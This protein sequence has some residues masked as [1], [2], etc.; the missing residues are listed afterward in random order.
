MLASAMTPL[1]ALTVASLHGARFIGL[2]RDL[3]SLETGK[4]ADFM[5]LNTNPLENIRNTK[6][7]LYVMKGGVLYDDETLDEV[8]P[9]RTP[10]GRYPWV[11]SEAL[12]SDD[13]PIRP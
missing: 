13:R 7:I 6:D 3:G 2:E 10:Y 5:V 11:N 8:W 12:R 1:Q 4:L 9:N